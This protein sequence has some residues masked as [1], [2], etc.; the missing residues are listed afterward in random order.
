MDSQNGDISDNEIFGRDFKKALG[1]IKAKAYV[2]PGQYDLYFPP[3]DSKF[4]VANMPNAKFLPVPSI[5]GHSA[6]GPGTNRMMSSSS[7]TR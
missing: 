3:Q 7:I 2:M 5:W 1:A 4:E 6:G